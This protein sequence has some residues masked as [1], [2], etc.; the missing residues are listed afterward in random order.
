MK[1]LPFL[2]HELRLIII[3]STRIKGYKNP[4]KYVLRKYMQN[5]NLFDD[6]KKYV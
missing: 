5:S 1:K 2:F 4:N 3:R 6:F